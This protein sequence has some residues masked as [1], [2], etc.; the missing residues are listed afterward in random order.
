MNIHVKPVKVRPVHIRAARAR[1]ITSP[2]LRGFSPDIRLWPSRAASASQPAP[3]RAP[4][5]FLIP[6][7]TSR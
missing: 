5:G 1:Q 2:G 4:F 3:M 7:T 6:L